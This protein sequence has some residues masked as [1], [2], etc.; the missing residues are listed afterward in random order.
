MNRRSYE[1]NCALAH[2]LDLIGE[3]WT[4]LIIRE[5]LLEAKRF[6]ELL[7]RLE[8]IGTNLLAKRLKELEQ[9]GIIE[10][11]HLKEDLRAYSYSL[12]EQGREL[13]S[14]LFALIR[15]HIHH[16]PLLDGQGRSHPE[17][18]LIALKALFRPRS[19]SFPSICLR[20]QTP[21][22][23]VDLKTDG[24]ELEFVSPENETVDSTIS[25]DHEL[26][27]GIFKKAIPWSEASKDP[28]FYVHGDEDKG[29]RVL[30][31]FE[32]DTSI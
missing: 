3:R 4:L 22:V 25:A 31:C 24:L 9:A 10:K 2:A 30:A 23:T 5:L 21:K 26:M 8:G 14:V 19:D 16:H 20:I 13:E 1:Q 17:W 32:I 12:T 27:A 28:S 29:R 15:W 7:Q 6:K 11:L 18:D